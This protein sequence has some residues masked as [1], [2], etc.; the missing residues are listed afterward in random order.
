MICQDSR[1]VPLFP[2]KND[3]SSK[4]DNIRKSVFPEG[5]ESMSRLFEPLKI[6]T[7]TLRNRICVSPMCQYS[8]PDGVAG[9]WHM[10]HLGSRAVGGAGVVMVE[11]SAVSPEGRITPDDLGIW[12]D[13]QAEALA[14]IV[15]FMKRFG[16]VCGIQIA[17]AGRKASTAAPFKGGHP[18]SSS[19]G[20]WQT[21]GPSAV[22]FGNYPAPRAMEKTDLDKVRNDFREAALRALSARFDILELHLAHGY[23]LHNF[24]SPLSNRRTDE[25]GGSLENRMR[26]PL[27]VVRTVREVWP[28]TLPLWVRISSTDWAEGGWDPDMSVELSR[29]LKSAGVDVIDASSGGLTPD[30]VIP[31]GPGYQTAIAARIRREVDIPVVAVG[32]ITDPVQAEHALLTGQADLVSLA[33]EMLRDPYWPLHAAH[34]LGQNVAWPAQ[35]ER[36]KPR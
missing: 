3:G 4:K 21:L 11:A 28:E 26:F 10:V 23:L 22:P 16:A 36:A 17:H 14:P 32:M 2:R 20:S 31:L 27:E 33:R 6:K 8:T 5:G 34:R 13:R 18:L 29:H 35:Y 19:E 12:S 15:S 24:L 30:A 25:Y 7:V 1:N 9:D